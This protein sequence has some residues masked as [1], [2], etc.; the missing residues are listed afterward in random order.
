MKAAWE[1]DICSVW[2]EFSLMACFNFCFL[3]LKVCNLKFRTLFLIFVNYFSFCW[4]INMK[5]SLILVTNIYIKKWENLNVCEIYF[6]DYILISMFAITVWSVYICCSRWYNFAWCR[7]FTPKKARIFNNKF[8]DNIL[9][10]A[11][12]RY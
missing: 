8:I 6:V 1:P 12:C 3:C 4:V 7:I 11:L 2:S 9:C 5:S 10:C